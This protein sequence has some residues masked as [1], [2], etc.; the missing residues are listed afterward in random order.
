M[1]TVPQGES[2][3]LKS[4]QSFPLPRGPSALSL[5]LQEPRQKL[6]LGGCESC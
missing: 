3:G 5:A 6:I 4:Q 2:R 1:L